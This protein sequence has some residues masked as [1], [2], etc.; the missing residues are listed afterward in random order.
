MNHELTRMHTNQR[1]AAQ[2]FATSRESQAALMDAD[3]NN[4]L[5]ALGERVQSDLTLVFIGVH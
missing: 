3:T 1:E 2:I 5:S 4:V